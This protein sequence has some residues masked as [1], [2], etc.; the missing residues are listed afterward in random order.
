MHLFAFVF[1]CL[2][3]FVVSLRLCEVVCNYFQLLLGVSVCL[4]PVV[5]SCFQLF[6][7]VCSCLKLFGVICNYFAI[8]CSCLQLLV[9]V[10]CCLQ[11]FTVVFD[12]VQLFAVV[13]C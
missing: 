5:C 1:N 12:F 13:C 8:V 2:Q 10:C 7:V 6:A 11:L 3:S 9:V 4:F